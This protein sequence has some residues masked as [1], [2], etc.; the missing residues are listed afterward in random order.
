MAGSFERDASWICEI[1]ISSV[2]K[3]YFLHRVEREVTPMNSLCFSDENHTNTIANRTTLTQPISIPYV[4][5]VRFT[6][7]L[8]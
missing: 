4:K 2:L 3:N 6:R 7:H 5:V 1:S 8:V